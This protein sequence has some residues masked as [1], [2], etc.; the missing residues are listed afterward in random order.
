MKK[1]LIALGV[2]V[3]VALIVVGSL[4]GSRNRFVAADENINSQWSEV[5]TQIQRRADLIPNLVNTVKGFASHETEVFN[6][7][8]EARAKLAGARSIPEKIS[9]NNQMDSA[10]SRLLVVVENYPQLKSDKN[11]IAL[12]DELSGTENR[13]AVAR[14]NYNLALQNYNTMI[15]TFP[16]NIAAS[17]FGFQ[18]KDA[19]FQASES[20]KA[21]PQVNFD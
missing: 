6:G 17:M 18:K 21:V 9:A 5:D 2:I 16:G 8:A 14:R 20:A 12:Q 3:I 11:F 1:V 10:L 15:R 7:I 13:I 4:V 19:Y